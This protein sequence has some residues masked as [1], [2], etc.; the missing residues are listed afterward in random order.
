MTDKTVFADW[1]DEH[2]VADGSLDARNPLYDLKRI[3]G[4]D[5][6]ARVITTG[7]GAHHV[8]EFY[9]LLRYLATADSPCTRSKHPSPGPPRWM[10]GFREAMAR[11]RN[12]S[13]RRRWSRL[14]RCP[15]GTST[16]KTFLA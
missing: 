1:V 11:R 12:S 7:D 9:R 2:A 8:R 5:D 16:R 6:D 4:R 14:R 10:P 15:T 13:G 3:P